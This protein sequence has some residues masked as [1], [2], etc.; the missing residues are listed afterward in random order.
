MATI[1]RREGGRR[2]REGGRK[3]RKEALLLSEGRWK[4]VESPSVPAAHLFLL[5]ALPRFLS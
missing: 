2:G 3:G 1:K 5:P 4:T